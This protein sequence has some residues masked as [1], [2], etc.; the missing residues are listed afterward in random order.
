MVDCSLNNFNVFKFLKIKCESSKLTSDIEE[1]VY[2]L[3]YL[4]QTDNVIL[5]KELS[6]ILNDLS[7]YDYDKIK[8]F[9][10]FIVEL[11]YSKLKIKKLLIEIDYMKPELA[12]QIR[13]FNLY[14]YSIM[15]YDNIPNYPN[16]FSIYKINDLSVYKKKTLERIVG[17]LSKNER[18]NLR[19]YEKFLVKLNKNIFKNEE[20]ESSDLDLHTIDNFKTIEE[21]DSSI[22]ENKLNAEKNINHNFNAKKLEQNFDYVLEF[23]KPYLS[24]KINPKDFGYKFSKFSNFCTIIND[25]IK[26]YGIKDISWD[27]NIYKMNISLPSDEFILDWGNTRFY[28]ED[29]NNNLICLSGYEI[30]NYND[31]KNIYTCILYSSEIVIFK[32]SE[33][34]FTHSC[35]CPSFSDSFIIEAIQDYESYHLGIKLNLLNFSFMVKKNNAEIKANIDYS[36]NNNEKYVSLSSYNLRFIYN[37]SLESRIIMEYCKKNNIKYSYNNDEVSMSLNL[38]FKHEL[39]AAFL[40]L[41]YNYNNNIQ[42]NKNDE[43]SIF[44]INEFLENYD[45]KNYEK[46]LYY[47]VKYPNISLSNIDYYR[48]KN[49]YYNDVIQLVKSFTSE[50]FSLQLEFLDK[51]FSITKKSLYNIMESYEILLKENGEFV[52]WKSEYS[53]FLIAKSFYKQT[54][55]QYKPKYL[56]AQS[57]DIY[58]PELN[59]GIEYQGLQHYENV[60]YFH[61]NLT[62]NKIR[63]NKKKDICEKFNLK[64]VYW[65][66]DRKINAE[67]FISF[68]Q[69]NNVYD[70]PNISLDNIKKITHKTKKV[71]TK[72]KKKVIAQYSIEGKLIN[73]FSSIKDAALEVGISESAISYA[74]NGKSLSCKNFLWRRYDSKQNVKKTIEIP[75]ELK[76]VTIKLNNGKVLTFEKLIDAAAYLSIKK[77]ILIGYL[78]IESIPINDL[79]L[80]IRICK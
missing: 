20:K 25:Q 71:I 75:I 22:L 36:Y 70:I 74:V 42:I 23:L 32:N 73:K 31:V 48:A 19:S 47:L 26:I 21:F 50:N 28:I 67:N 59:I 41:Y 8:K 66:Y 63:D 54:V 62:E 6:V 52:Q 29:Y 4:K 34:Y 39:K 55:F 24:E 17:N 65:K 3:K 11:Y 37:Y 40:Y 53:L 60:E 5:L 12:I 45:A 30:I 78:N 61:N 9:F 49:A 76:K 77:E 64:L 69:K 38:D 33:K 72:K 35:R 16:V 79:I 7:L 44:I 15:I 2:L 56:G 46:I 27:G 14:L 10:Y 51:T 80:D 13:Q 68:L 1:N 57:I 43:F 58:I 18:I